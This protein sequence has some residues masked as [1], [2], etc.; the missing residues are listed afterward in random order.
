MQ[1][2]RN[3]DGTTRS[4]VRASGS[5]LPSRVPGYRIAV[6]PTPTS[7]GSIVNPRR[8]VLSAVLLGMAGAAMLVPGAGAAK[9]RVFKNC[10]AANKVYAHGAVDV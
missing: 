7:K 9:P 8:T 5:I 10:T 4:V 1:R 3:Q 6:R 2:E